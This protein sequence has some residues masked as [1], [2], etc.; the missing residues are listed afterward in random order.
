MGR[1]ATLRIDILADAKGVGRGV[2]DADSH[3]SRLG[4]GA[5]RVGLAVGAGLAAGV[6][7]VG[8][9]AK[10]AV[11]EASHVQQSFGGLEAV[12]GKNART[13][14]AWANGAAT[15]VGLSKAEYADLAAVIGSQLTGMHQPLDEA[16]RHT[17]DL[18]KM[19]ADLAATFGGSTKDAVEALSSTLKGEF[20]PIER[21][22]I[23]I[24]QSDINARLAAEGHDKLTGAAL[25]TATAQ[26]ALEMIT[27]ASAK[28]H[29]QFAAQTSTLA[30]QQQILGAKFDNVKAT[31]GAALIPILTGLFVFVSSTLG[32]GIE[33]LAGQLGTQLGPT[34]SLVGHFITSQVIPA[35]VQL[36]TWYGS[37][38]GPV[39][40]Q[41]GHIISADLIPVFL[42]VAH[43][44]L[45]RV[46]PAVEQLAGP[47]FG[48]L[49]SILHSVGSAVDAHREQLATLGT[50]LET[51][52]GWVLKLAKPIGAVLG[53][54]LS[55]V[56]VILGTT[57]TVIADLVGWLKT[58][59]D[60][61]GK[62]SGP[63]SKV[64][65]VIG[66][67][68]GI[69]GGPP[70]AGGIGGLIGG[71]PS[72]AP[73]GGLATAALGDPAQLG[74]LSRSQGGGRVLVLDQRTIDGRIYVDGALDPVAVARQLSDLLAD[75]DVR[76]GRATAWAPGT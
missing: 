72:Y 53:P 28:A 61:V 30:E 20:D 1:P 59:V 5:K 21:Y 16:T 40:A 12:F 27:E 65:G 26:A 2:D 39:L 67:I 10:S 36:V 25:K 62:L 64:G 44:I 14:K 69:F 49:R 8:A 57:I 51:V 68:G 54:A 6:V 73:G 76:L 23:S 22:G 24:K 45:T 13:V 48:G 46:V 58:A 31:I 75:H 43:F 70:L 18:V 34:L 60:W 63:L 4:T 15:A 47:I 35:A 17:N 37:H 38:V 9:F 71:S 50:A 56:G 7:A 52:A 32:P 33:R 3:L 74:L 41:V 11:D 66:K 19:G 55:A 29:G 42:S